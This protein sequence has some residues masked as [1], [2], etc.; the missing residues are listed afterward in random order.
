MGKTTVTLALLAFLTR[1]GYRVQSFKVG[2]D[3]IDP[4]FHTKVTGI[5][6]R[7]LDPILTGESYVRDCYATYSGNGDLS[8]IE[9]VMGLYDGVRFPSVAS[10]LPD[11]A[12]TAHIARLLNLPVV[13]VI[14]C[15]RLSGSVA[16]IVQGYR[17]LDPSLYIMGVILNKVASDR[18]LIL[19]KAALEAVEMPILGVLRR[20][21]LTI[22]DRHLG[23]IPTAEIP[24]I[25]ELFDKLATLADDSFDW[26]KILPRLVSDHQGPIGATVAGP[27]KVR[28]GVAYDRAFNFYYQ[29]NLDILQK[30]GAEI[31]PWS[32]LKDAS[33][34][35]NIGGLYLG[36]GFPEVFAAELAWNQPLRQQLKVAIQ[37]GLPCYAECGGLMYLCEHL[38]DFD[39]KIWPM[40]GVLPTRS[41]M[42]R[43]LTLGYRQGQAKTATCVIESSISVWGHEFHHSHLSVLPTSPLYRSQSLDGVVNYEGW[44]LHRVH[45]SYLH[46]HFGGCEHIARKFINSCV[47]DFGIDTLT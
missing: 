42:S 18:H 3:Y 30:L 13:L 35:E 7:N 4:M 27:K 8:L 37:K 23:L 24:Q 41:I 15:S 40:V 22:P 47:V 14:D 5:P 19:L 36:G 34:P 12:S 9:G 16:A 46:L 6:C 32:P 20:H 39:G 33:L 17:S 11:Y 45:A 2:P 10:P 21:D 28:I 25:D 29:D 1:Q 44:A 26:E 38:Q 43:K 31:V